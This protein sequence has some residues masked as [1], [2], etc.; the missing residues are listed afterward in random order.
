MVLKKALYNADLFTAENSKPIH[1]D[2]RTNTSDIDYVISSLAIYNNIQN[3]TLNNNLSFDHSAILY[4]FS[5]KSTNLLPVLS[6]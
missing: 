3:R 5:A 4:D 2:S 1:R 6:K